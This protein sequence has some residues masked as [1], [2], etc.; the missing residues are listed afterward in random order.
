MVQLRTP[1]KRHLRHGAFARTSRSKHLR[2][3][4]ADRSDDLTGTG[5]AKT[6]VAGGTSAAVAA[7][8]LLTF[9]GN[10]ANADTVTIGGVT[11]TF[12][13]VLG[14]ANSILIGLDAAASRTNLVSAIMLTAG[15]GTTYGVGT[16]IH[17]TVA[18]AASG[19]NMTVTAKVA[20][21]AGNAIATTE[22]S[23]VL[24]FGAATLTGGA[25]AVAT[26]VN[27]TVTA[28]G[29]VV[30]AGPFL[31]T[32]ATTL[33]AGLRLLTPYWVKAVVNA[34][35]LTLSTARSD[36]PAAAYTSAGTGAHTLT[37]AS[38]D[39]ALYDY[40]KQNDPAVVKNATDVD[41]L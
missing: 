25:A 12:N 23:T 37:K 16:V 40:L 15:S 34:N 38:D 18:V 28:H 39:P 1:R 3:F 13:T 22:A 33:P 32:T 36:A 7:T 26:A 41:A 17:P 10:P 29:L 11:Y 24:S 30:G 8:G 4:V 20:G 19:A 6:F 9:A 27:L 14:A 31:L 5:A 21:T 35:T 2:A